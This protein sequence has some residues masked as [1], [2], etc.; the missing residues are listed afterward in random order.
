MNTL[1]ICL[2]AKDEEA[3]LPRCLGCIKDIADEIVVVDTGSRD[4]TAAEARKFTQNVCFFEWRDDFSAARNFSFAQAHCDLIMWLDADDVITEENIAKIA[5]LKS[6]D[7]FDVAMLPYAVAFDERDNPTFV[8][9]RERIFRRAMGWEWQGA[10]H[11]A[12]T[13]RGRVINCDACIYH[14]KIRQNEPMR[15]LRIY[16]RLISEGKTLTP[17]EKFYYGRELFFNKMYSE[18]IAVLSDFIAGEGWAENKVEACRTLCRAFTALGRADEAVKA[19]A[20]GFLFSFP[21]AEDCCI[22][23]AHFE[24]VNDLRSARYWYERALDSPERAEDG[25][26]VDKNYSGFFPAMKLCVLCDRAG[27]LKKAYYYNELA[28]SF[29]PDDANYIYNKNYFKSKGVEGTL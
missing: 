25:G 2:I 18:S 22:L 12:I 17:R 6:R 4:N 27:D 8:Y 29:R 14:R 20:C 1:S 5:A 11:E 26:F 21:H 16:Q 10:V 24:D 15:N 3:V 7:D 9:Y 13:P 28:G 19:L 23:A